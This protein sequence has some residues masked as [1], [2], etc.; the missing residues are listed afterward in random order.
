MLFLFMAFFLELITYKNLSLPSSFPCN[1][2]SFLPFAGIR[3]VKARFAGD[4]AP[5]CWRLRLSRLGVK[6]QHAGSQGSTS[7]VAVLCKCFA[8]SAFADWKMGT[9]L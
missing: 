9:S 8:I 3:A 2:F 4:Q 1:I 6:A 7:C 5:A